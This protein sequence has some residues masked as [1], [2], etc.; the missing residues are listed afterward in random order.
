V[1]IYIHFYILYKESILCTE[2]IV[3]LCREVLVGSDCTSFAHA[4]YRVVNLNGAVLPSHAG[5][6]EVGHTQFW[7]SC[8]R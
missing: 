4:L 5:F 7:I 8:I 3:S 6:N 1:F 2:F